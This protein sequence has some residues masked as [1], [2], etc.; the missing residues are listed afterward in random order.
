MFLCEKLTQLN[1]QKKRP[2]HHQSNEF[3]D[4]MSRTA[5]I[6][7]V[8]VAMDGYVCP[9]YQQMLDHDLQCAKVIA[10]F[11]LRRSRRRRCCY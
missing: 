10:T 2:A 7:H 1:R 9:L 3:C 6:V 4:G 8:L 5:T 11:L